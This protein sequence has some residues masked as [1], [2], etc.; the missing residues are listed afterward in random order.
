MKTADEVLKDLLDQG[1]IKR[2]DLEGYNLTGDDMKR[3]VSLMHSI[4][5][6]KDHDLQRTGIVGEDALPRECTYLYECE[7][8][9]PWEEPIHIEWIQKA[10]RLMS[11][12]EL[13]Y[14]VDLITSLSLALDAIK[15]TNEKALKIVMMLR[16][17]DFFEEVTNG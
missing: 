9:D 4:F 12:L 10:G 16:D 8:E 13:R 6:H 15:I 2:E 1:K 11:S 17:P 5:C 14:E 3:L 7:K